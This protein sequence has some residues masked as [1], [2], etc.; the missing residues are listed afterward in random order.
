MRIDD[1]DDVEILRELAKTCRCK[2][3]KD[4]PSNDGKNYLFHAGEWYM[5]SQSE[6]DITLYSEDIA[7][8][9]VCLSYEQAEAYLES[10]N[11]ESEDEE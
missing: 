4:L 6:Y 3:I 9:T 11:N 8:A 7:N 10:T 2:L 1:I 5:V